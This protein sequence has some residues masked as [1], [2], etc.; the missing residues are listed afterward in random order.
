MVLNRFDEMKQKI[1]WRI[2]IIRE[3]LNLGMS[4]VTNIIVQE[5]KSILVIKI[6]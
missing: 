6:S 1:P 4:I 2:I 5:M 3:F